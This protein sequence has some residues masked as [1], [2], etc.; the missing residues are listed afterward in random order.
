MWLRLW[1][2]GFFLFLF[3]LHVLGALESQCCCNMDLPLG[4]SVQRI[5]NV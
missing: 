2:V 4:S 1:C 3:V 5:V